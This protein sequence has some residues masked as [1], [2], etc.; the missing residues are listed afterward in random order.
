MEWYHY[1]LI[2]LGGMFIQI[3][4]GVIQSKMIASGVTQLENRWQD[5]TKM[6]NSFLGLEVMP[7]E[8]IT[9]SFF[10]FIIWPFVL[11]GL[12]WDN[13]VISLDDPK[14]KPNPLIKD[15]EEEKLDLKEF[16]KKKTYK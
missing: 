9:F 1:L 4:F 14:K 16:V 2:Y 11:V 6:H 3:L 7:S 13:V 12:F 8:Y 15:A 5:R 10:W